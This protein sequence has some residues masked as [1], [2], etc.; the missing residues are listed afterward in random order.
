MPAITSFAAFV[1]ALFFSWWVQPAWAGFEQGVEAF[2][3]EAYAQ[4]E[5][6]FLPLAKAGHVQAMI[7]LGRVK[8]EQ[9]KAAEAAPWYLKAAQKG[10]AEA[11]TRLASLYE[12]GAGV[13]HDQAQALSWYKKAALRGNDE[14][15]LALGEYAED[16]LGDEM[17]ALAWY[18]KAAAQSNAEAQ[19][20]LGLLLI[21]DGRVERDV[22]RAWMMFALAA[23]QG[24]DDAERA[25]DVLELEMEPVELRQARALLADWQKKH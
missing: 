7:Y 13:A 5:A 18:E 25:G 24:L 6:Q 14:A 12:A 21:A 22:P 2:E 4:A 11:Q 15:Q 16:V 17:A 3:N 8:E 19:Y 20:H 9:D 10:N 23:E 1:F